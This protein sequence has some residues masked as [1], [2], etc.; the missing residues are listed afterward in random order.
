MPHPSSFR[1]GSPLLLC[2]LLS[3]CETLKCGPQ[4]L[5]MYIHLAEQTIVSFF[6]VSHV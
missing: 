1:L 5:Q 4:M 3:C 6:S 2:Q